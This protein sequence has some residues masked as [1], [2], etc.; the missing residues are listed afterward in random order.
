MSRIVY[1]EVEF[2]HF[3]P[4]CKYE[5]LS[6]TKD[7]CN[8]CLESFFNIETMKPVKFEEKEDKKEKE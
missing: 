4:K 6:E 7:P 8:E 2:Y 3:C 5:K 1:K